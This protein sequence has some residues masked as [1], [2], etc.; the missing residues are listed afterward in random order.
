MSIL[1]GN[2]LLYTAKMRRFAVRW[3]Y[4]TGTGNKMQLKLVL[5]PDNMKH[6]WTRQK[7]TTYSKE[8]IH[9]KEQQAGR[10]E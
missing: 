5:M 8:S 6:V 3:L 7:Q 9:V 1:Y 10:P 4:V 2:F